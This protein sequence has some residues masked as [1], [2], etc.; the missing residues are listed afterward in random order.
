MPHFLFLGAIQA[1][2]RLFTHHLTRI[3][4][5][6]RKLS[7]ALVLGLFLYAGTALFAQEKKPQMVIGVYP[8]KTVSDDEGLKQ[9]AALLTGYVNQALQ[10]TKQFEVIDNIHVDAVKLE[11]QKQKEG[12]YISGLIAQQFVARGTQ[13]L[14][15]GTLHSF[16]A[17][18]KTGEGVG[19]GLMKGITTATANSTTVSLGFT[20]DIVDVA[21]NR[22]L[23]TRTFDVSGTGASFAD[24]Q[25]QAHRTAKR[26][27][28]NWLVKQ[29]DYDFQIVNV[30][31]MNKKGFPETVLINGGTN[32]DLEKAEKLEVVELAKVGDLNREIPVCT[33]TVKEVQGEVT[34][35]TVNM[36]DREGLQTKLDAKVPLKIW[37]REIKE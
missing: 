21:T 17:I 13:K 20:L 6:D 11:R 28:S 22:M 1:P 2:V 25:K 33:L 4:S 14:L 7:I 24:A 16:G 30:E 12:D 35:C 19:T 26:Q 3:H 32:M 5:M 18:K 34:V 36:N 29:L 10:R 37:F 23:D 27:F 15:T 31:S 8:I 9:E